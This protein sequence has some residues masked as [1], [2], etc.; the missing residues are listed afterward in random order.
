[1]HFAAQPGAAAFGPLPL[2]GD[3]HLFC[4]RRMAFSSFPYLFLIHLIPCS[5]ASTMR[6]HRSVLHRMVAFSVDMRSLG[7]PWLFHVATSASSVSR[8]RGSR[9][10]VM[11][12]GTCGAEA[13]FLRGCCGPG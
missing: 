1:M 10:S 3:Q 8:L 11:G 4:P 2:W 6:G 13:L 9:P 7:S 5:W 12:M